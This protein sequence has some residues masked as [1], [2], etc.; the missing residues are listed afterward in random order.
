MGHP[1][2]GHSWEGYCI[3]QILALLPP[4]TRASHY[5]THAGAEVDLVLESP[6]GEVTC[7][8]IKRTVSPKLSPGFNE[9]FRTIAATR[10]FIITPSGIAF[11]LS[12]KVEAISLTDFITRELG[13]GAMPPA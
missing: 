6:S 4:D 3:E 11:P 7:I 13:G 10:G 9:S 1:L 5:R 12:G 8:E 2:C